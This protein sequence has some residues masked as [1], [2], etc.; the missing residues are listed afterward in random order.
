MQHGTAGGGSA[1][2]GRIAEAGFS[3]AEKA[4]YKASLEK[5]FKATKS[6]DMSVVAIYNDDGTYK[7]PEQS[8]KGTCYDQDLLAALKK[9]VADMGLVQSKDR[10][11]DVDKSTAAA[12]DAAQKSTSDS[13]KLATNAGAVRFR[14]RSDPVKLTSKAAKEISTSICKD[15]GELAALIGTATDRNG[16]MELYMSSLSETFI[17]IQALKSRV[18]T[19]LEK[20]RSTNVAMGKVLE[21]L[22]GKMDQAKKIEAEI[23]TALGLTAAEIATIKEHTTKRKEGTDFFNKLTSDYN[24][25]TVALDAKTGVLTASTTALDGKTAATN[26][27]TT[28]LDGKTA[29]TD[30]STAALDGKTA[31]TDASTAALDGKTA[32]TNTATDAQND[33]K[34]ASDAAKA[35]SDAQAAAD[36]TATGVAV[37]GAAAAKQREEAYKIEIVRQQTSITMM[38]N[39]LAAMDA[40]MKETQE[41]YGWYADDFAGISQQYGA[42]FDVFDFCDKIRCYDSC[43]AARG[44]WPV[45][46]SCEAQDAAKDLISAIT[47]DVPKADQD[48]NKADDVQHVT[49]PEAL[50]LLNGFGCDTT[51]QDPD[52]VDDTPSSYDPKTSDN[53]KCK[54]SK[55]PYACIHPDSRENLKQTIRKIAGAV[56]SISQKAKVPIDYQLTGYFKGS[57]TASSTQQS[58]SLCRAKYYKN[59]IVGEAKAMW[60]SETQP[61]VPNFDWICVAAGTE[62]AEQPMTGVAVGAKR[63]SLCPVV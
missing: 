50:F 5:V 63:G 31:A 10:F 16:A 33:A 11:T 38:E 62:L 1:T 7:A 49:M 55:T 52:G 18:T 41:E 32:A 9:S 58:L 53:K 29:A 35:A 26:A 14:A 47:A 27:A 22:N 15:A 40:Q 17:A 46:S 54:N 21:S 44:K 19:R 2:D 43:R 23:K 28:T 36:G 39:S 30:A 13:G 60:D 51:G 34:D 8:L 25:A 12:A 20:F 56:L 4:K 37:D 57:G 45:M 48:P 61:A 59:L 6:M 3:D 42:T 24:G